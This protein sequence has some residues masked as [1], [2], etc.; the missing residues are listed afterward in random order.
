MCF[1]GGDAGRVRLLGR[2]AS[3]RHC[4][5]GRLGKGLR[6]VSEDGKGLADVLGYDGHDAQAEPARLIHDDAQR[7]V[8]VGLVPAGARA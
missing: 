5:R 7:Q 8:F 1:E 3:F 4:D 6:K 2:A